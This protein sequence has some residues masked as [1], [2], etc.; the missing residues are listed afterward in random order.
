MTPSNRIQRVSDTQGRAAWLVSGHE[1]V[2][3]LLADPRLSRSHPNPEH[4]VRLTQPGLFGGPIPDPEGE[5]ADLQRMRKLLTPSLSARRME[6]LRPRVETIVDALLDELGRSG[7]PADFHTIVAFPLPALVICELLGVPAEDRADFCR[8]QIEAKQ[9]SRP[10]VARGGLQSLWRY[11]GTLIERKRWVGSDDVISDL[12]DAAKRDPKLTDDGIAHLAAGLLFAGHAPVVA[13]I[14]RGMLLLLTHSEQREA[15]RR[16]P[17]LAAGAVEEIFRFASP[18]ERLR[19]ARR[20]GLT[21]YASVDIEVEGATIRAGDTVMF[22]VQEA[23]EDESVF[24]D[25]KRFDITRE[26]IPHLSLS[27]GAHFCLGAHLARVKL[28]YLFVRS[29][30]RFPRLRLAVP[31]E[32]IQPVRDAVAG[33]VSRLPVIW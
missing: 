6:S 4:P 27:H 29:F 10:A 18:I 26:R 30:E 7:S 21:R 28:Q 12:L 19:T 20:G 33:A 25:P 8:W 11:L 22:A 9:V 15:L 23:N 14:D 32:E 24:S 13:I 5:L 16:D 17:A 2:R 3:E 1:W 31:L